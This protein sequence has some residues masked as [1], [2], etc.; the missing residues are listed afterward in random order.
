LLGR[1]ANIA[2]YY[3]RLFQEKL[4]YIEHYIKNYNMEMM[5][6]MGRAYGRGFEAEKVEKYQVS[7]PSNLLK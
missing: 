2:A 4:R 3:E 6:I 7:V 5:R 1:V